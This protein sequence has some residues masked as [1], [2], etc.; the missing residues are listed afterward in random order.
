[1][2]PPNFVPPT[3]AEIAMRSAAV[4]F[5]LAA[6]L[7]TGAVACGMVVSG[8][9]AR[10][11]SQESKRR[12]LRHL[13]GATGV[14]ANGTIGVDDASLL[15]FNASKDPVKEALRMLMDDKVDPELRTHL[16]AALAV[17][18]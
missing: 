17:S 7:V 15:F 13:A 2:L 1:M 11:S 12:F 16:R 8:V 14:G 18:L 10:A 9:I 5:P 3:L 6:A 4:N